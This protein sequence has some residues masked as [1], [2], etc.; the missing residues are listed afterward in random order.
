MDAP[1]V[2]PARLSDIPLLADLAK[3]TWADAFGGGVS[4]EDAATALEEERSEDYFA[5]AI[6]EKTILV[7]EADGALLAYAQFGDVEIAGVEVQPGDQGLQRL[8][9][10]TVL[11][12]R[13]LGRQLME[14]A[15]Q[16]PRLA[17]ARRI[18]LQVWAENARAVALYE[19]LGFEKVGSTT[20]AIGSELVQDLVMV[21][22]M[23]K[24]LPA[25]PTGIS[26]SAISTP[27]T[28]NE[29]A[30]LTRSVPSRGIENRDKRA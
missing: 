2:R 3:R 18:F 25:D 22:D 9:V 24:A 23:T 29:G 19:S 12:G 21:L 27:P 16:H 13:G 28:R 14:A 5:E 17:K 1:T 20:F 4:A 8:Y 26:G 10:E 15:L 11:H 30:F 7:T 6:R